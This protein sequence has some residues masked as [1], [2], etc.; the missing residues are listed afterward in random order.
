MGPILPP[1]R[2][3]PATIVATS[4][5]LVIKLVTLVVYAPS[6]DAV[7]TK[8]TR[9]VMTASVIPDAHAAGPEAPPAIPQ[10]RP[11]SSADPAASANAASPPSPA[12]AR[13]VTPASARQVTP[14]S[15][16]QVTPASARQVSPAAAQQAS[17][18]AVQ[19]VT[20]GAA[21][22]VTPVAAQQASP[23]AVLPA[24]QVAV[25]PAAQ[26]GADA[27][28]A[29]ITLHRS[30]I[31]QRERLLAQ[32]EAAEAA[33]EK[34]LTDRVGELLALQSHLQALVNDD[35][36]HEEA[37][38]AGLVKLY[39]GMR[40]RDAAV[41]FNGLDKPVLLEIL[42]RM[43]PAKAAPVIALMEPENARQVTADLAARRSASAPVTN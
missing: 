13:Q 20:P 8:T 30:Q 4:V 3:L 23:A 22:Q 2:L 1:S 33:A 27:A 10:Q 28:T 25:Q 19:Q 21:Q 38:W 15:A 32:R 11:G 26:S 12:S 6:P 5:V 7:W 29:E 36:Q 34:R 9:A 42:N 17:P 41:I 18:A 39:E 24:R 43:K 14:A 35:K 31:E 37:K 40:P 16:R